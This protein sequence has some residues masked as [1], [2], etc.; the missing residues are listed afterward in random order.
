V[1][2]GLVHGQRCFFID[3]HSDDGFFRRPS[4][5]GAPDDVARFA[6]FSK[7]AVEFMLKT[8][9]RPDVIHCHDWQTALVPVLLYEIYKFAGMPDQRVCLTIHNFGQQGLVEDWV[10]QATGLG[11][12]EYFC[13]VDRLRDDINPMLINLLKGGIVYSNYV[14]TVSP[15]HAWET[16][17]TEHGNGLGHTLHVHR[18][19]YQG[20]LNGVDYEVWN[21]EIDDMIPHRFTPDRLE[22]KYANKQALRDR[23]WLRAGYKPVVSYIGRI[24]HQKGVH[25]I[26]HALRY[27]LAASAQFIVLGTSTQSEVQNQFMRLK[28]ELNDNP[29]CHLELSFTPELGHLAYAGSDLIVVPSMF[30]PC[31][32][33]QLIALKYGTVPVV[34]HTGGLVDTI[35]DREYSDRPPAERNGYVFHDVDGHAMEWALGRAIGLWFDYPEEFR[36]LMRRGMALDNSWARSGWTYLEIYERIRHK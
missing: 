7:A 5:Y 3:P 23:F 31:G 22:G 18:D 28:A 24:D 14:T 16:Q 35:Q 8:N 17:H 11:R 13:H 10:L 33:V 36:L 30:E 34:R 12:P 19:K 4:L 9:R 15:H 27:A 32:L 29:D 25:L 2:T 21:P 6:F 1:W 20:V 26:Q